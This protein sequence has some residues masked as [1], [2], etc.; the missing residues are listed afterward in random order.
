MVLG[1]L[2]PS[3]VVAIPSPTHHQGRLELC[4]PG[5]EAAQ[6]DGFEPC[7]ALQG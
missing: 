1:E 4:V 2:S 7:S 3:P 6:Q 5:E